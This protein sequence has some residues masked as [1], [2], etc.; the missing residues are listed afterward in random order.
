MNHSGFLKIGLRFAV[1]LFFSALFAVLGRSQTTTINNPV[2]VSTHQGGQILVVDGDT[3]AVA[4][5]FSSACGDGGTCPEGVVVGPDNKIYMADPVSRTIR[6]ID[7]SG[8]NFE[9]LITSCVGLSCP[10]G[11]QAPNFSSSLAGDLYFVDKTNNVYLIAGAAKTAFGGPFS[12]PVVVLQNCGSGSPFCEQVLSGGTAFDK[13]DNFL[14]DGAFGTNGT[15][16]SAPPPYN[17][18]P[19]VVALAQVTSPKAIAL[20]KSTGQVFVADATGEILFIGSNTTTNYYTFASPDIPQYMQFDAA[21]RLFVTTAQNTISPYHGKVWRVDPPIP[22]STNPTATLLVDLNT[23]YLNY[24]LGINSDQADGLALPPTPYPAISIP[25]NPAGGTNRYIFANGAFDYKIVYGPPTPASPNVNLVVQA[26]QE[27]QQQLDAF[28]TGTSFAGATLAPYFGTGGYGI[29]FVATCQNATTLL[30][31]PCPQF[32]DPYEVVTNYNG[33]LPSNVAF[34]TDED[35]LPY[36]SNILTSASAIRTGDP[37]IVGHKK[38]ALSGFQVVGGVTGTPPTVTIT[39]P[40]NT[41][42]TLNQIV[43]ASYSCTGPNVTQCLGTVS[44]GAAIDTASAGTKTFTVTAL[45]SGG[46]TASSTVT[47]TVIA[48]PVATVSPSSVNFGNVEVGRFAFAVVTLTNTGQAP[49]HVK[50]VKTVSVP[51]GD[52]DDFF[53]FSTCP[54]TLAVGKS[55]YIWV[56][57][58]ADG[59]SFKPQSATLVIT[60][61][62]PGSPQLV[63]LTATVVKDHEE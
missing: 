48:G 38:P 63:P 20:N 52:S 6:R 7:R 43:L 11:P 13:T 10:T 34:L 22:P 35:N 54:N 27:T 60:D 61:D 36:T 19:A 56:L 9:T 15:V 49:L 33:L 46:P 3:G 8:A 12:N 28:T 50:S 16:W 25:L 44:N 17:S 23:I 57:F 62:A 59:D 53:A 39:S 55:C 47:Y 14:F 45:V 40:T 37:T 42:Y 5:L 26:L 31:I 29:R 41:T 32:L 51:N 30:T 58:Y 2:Y 4:V 24:L 21:G 18:G 1:V